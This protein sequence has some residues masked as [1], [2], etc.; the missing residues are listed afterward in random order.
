MI[1]VRDD[2]WAVILFLLLD[3]WREI[4]KQVSGL[5]NLLLGE[6]VSQRIAEKVGIRNIIVWSSRVQL[7]PGQANEEVAPESTV[8]LSLP[9]EGEFGVDSS[10]VAIVPEMEALLVQHDVLRRDVRERGGHERGRD[11]NHD[12]DVAVHGPYGGDLLGHLAESR[13]LIELV[14]PQKVRWDVVG[15]PWNGDEV[16]RGAGDL[17]TVLVLGEVQ[18]DEDVQQDVP[19]CT[20]R[21]PEHWAAGLKARSMLDTH[22]LQREKRTVHHGRER[23]GTYRLLFLSTGGRLGTGRRRR[24]V[25]RHIGGAISSRQ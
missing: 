1:V 12:V 5:R 11:S 15:I 17:D 13:T 21:E 14:R 19:S 6:V 20:Q 22:A 24:C 23:R 7:A 8:L 4:I 9:G 10:L 16:T 3:G 25:L 18:I 2:N